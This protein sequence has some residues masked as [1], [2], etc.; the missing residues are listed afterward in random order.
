VAAQATLGAQKGDRE[1]VCSLT[2]TDG[3]VLRNWNEAKSV[4]GSS[5]LDHSGAGVT[6]DFS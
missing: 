1:A 4:N 3:E 5:S 2:N 6:S